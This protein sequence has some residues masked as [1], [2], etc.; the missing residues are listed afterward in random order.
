M[1]SEP[2]PPTLLVR[3]VPT[4][5]P[6]TVRRPAAPAKARSDL[7]WLGAILAL[8][9]V[10]RLISLNSP[11]WWDEIATVET[12][13]HMG[14]G[15]MVQDYSMNHHYL[16]NL[17]AKATMELFGEKPWAIR[18]PALV[19][20]LAAIAAMWVLVRDLA[21]AVPA[22]ATALL[23]ALSYHHI[24]FSQNAR[25]YTGMALFSTL[26]FFFFMRGLRTGQRGYWLAFAA[27]LAATVFTHL[28]G[29]FFFVALGLAWLGLMAAQAA[30]GA[31]DRKTVTLPLLGFVIGG[32]VTILVYMPLLPSLLHTVS[33]VSE[34]SAGDVMQEYQNPLWTAYEA[35]RSGIGETGPVVALVGL[36]VLVLTGAGAWALRKTAPLF[37]P[38]VIGHIVLTAALLLAVG[39][40][41]WPRFFFTDL[42]FLM[43]LIVMGVRLTCEILAR[44][45]PK[46]LGAAFFP[47]ALVAM[48]LV[49]SALA[50]R[51]YLSPKQD[52]AGAYAYV[53]AHRQNGD[54]VLTI[55]PDRDLLAHY[56]HTDWPTIFG[57]GD[58]RTLMAP[59]GPV[60]I[61]VVFPDRSFRAL[62]SLAADRDAKVL[63]EVKYFPGTLGDGGVFIL[64]R[65]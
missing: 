44:L 61:I 11:L 25:G 59:P 31:L 2:V 17:A 34:T 1:V 28:T 9:F 55:A 24:W 62:P 10:L 40:R 13:L 15:Q 37:A 43:F 54:R 23:L 20:G 22:H 8:A 21:G 27:S 49:S 19:F 14:W 51:N 7:F 47:L 29:A 65:R 57:D 33:A 35:I 48:A 42:A 46:R 4:T 38:I 12:H 30:R 26:G 32:V 18:L 60:T 41:I 64:S 6:H 58:Y 50:V 63:T 36:L 3:K 16:H 56:F 39:M 53:Q 45:A 5:T 52:L